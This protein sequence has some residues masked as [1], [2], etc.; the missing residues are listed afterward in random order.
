MGTEPT[1]GIGQDY[2]PFGYVEVD[3]GG[4]RATLASYAPTDEHPHEAQF[5]QEHERT[6]H[7]QKGQH[8]QGGQQIGQHVAHQNLQIAEPRGPGPLNV[9]LL[10]NAH[11]LATD[12]L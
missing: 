7:L 11:H 6:A 4:H 10:S 1:P 8:H 12:E 2:P 9:V 5:S 3:D